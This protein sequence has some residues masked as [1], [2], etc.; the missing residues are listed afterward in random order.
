[1]CVCILY[2]YYQKKKKQIILLVNKKEK[3]THNN[4]KKKR[5]EKIFVRLE[6]NHSGSETLVRLLLALYIFYLSL[7][8]RGAY[9]KFPDFFR[10]DT[11]IDSTHMKL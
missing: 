11:F 9:D 1:M 2:L 7:Y 6:N 5:K 3:I 4:S 8:K 10:M